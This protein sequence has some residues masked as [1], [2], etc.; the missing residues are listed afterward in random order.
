MIVA[1]FAQMWWFCVVVSLNS[2]QVLRHQDLLCLVSLTQLLPQL[3]QP[4]AWPFQ[5]QAWLCQLQAWLCRLQAWPCLLQAWL[6]HL[7]ALLLLVF[8]FH[9]LQRR[10]Q[11]QRYLVS[12]FL[13]CQF[14]SLALSHRSLLVTNINSLLF[15]I[16]CW[17]FPPDIVFLFYIELL[18]STVVLVIS[19]LYFF[20]V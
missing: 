20:P 15:C 4:Q 2:V 12:L 14:H 9:S 16:S 13:N 19:L 17:Q 1:H 8:Q 10:W 3:C 6:C 7:L 5:H 18:I 11:Q